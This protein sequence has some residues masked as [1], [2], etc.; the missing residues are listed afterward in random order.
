MKIIL[1]AIG[2]SLLIELL[3]IYLRLVVHKRSAPLQ[4]RLHLPRIHH[5]YPGFAVI[6]ID[7]VYLQNELLFAL[8]FALILSDVVHHLIFEP[9]IHKHQFDIGMKHHR[10]AHEY[11]AKFPAAIALIFVG[12]FALITPFTPG[13]WLSVIGVGMLA[14]KNPDDMF[15]AV[16]KR[17]PLPKVRGKTKSH[18]K[19]KKRVKRK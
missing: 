14:G 12:M 7:Y 6:L 11:V 13:S 4:K 16:I 2:L 10:K 17:L 3:T 8:G 18:N 5:S 9:F 1:L 15:K 19:S